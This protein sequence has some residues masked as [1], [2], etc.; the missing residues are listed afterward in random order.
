[1]H[2]FVAAEH[3]GR[4][5]GSALYNWWLERF[6]VQVR[7]FAVED[8]NQAMRRLMAAEGSAPVATRSGYQG[9]S[10]HFVAATHTPGAAAAAA[11]A[12]AAVGL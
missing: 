11:A 9:S 8:P 3:R 1:M 12:A 5:L 7:Y 10:L 6:A 4:G 2:L